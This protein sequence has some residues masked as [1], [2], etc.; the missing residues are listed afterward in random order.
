MNLATLGPALAFA[1]ISIC[2]PGPNN[3]ASAAM[4][5]LYG[6]RKTLPFLVGIC[7]SF[8]LMCLVSAWVARTLLAR[9]PALEALLTY[10]GAAYVIY[11]AVNILKTSYQFDA[12]P[13]ATTQPAGLWAGFTLQL[14]NPKFLVFAL[15]LFSTFFA[16][17]ARQ[18]RSLVLIA[19]GLTLISA[20]SVSS[21]T[22]F[23]SWVRQHMHRPALRH[24]VNLLLALLLAYSA[25]E[26]VR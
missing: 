12:R 22:L 8:F 10:A 26:M 25:L 17:E 11:L 20:F 13:S 3:I 4:G 2:T 18:A 16:A 19:L 7:L 24:T 6:F 23:G 1:L 21:W 5:T 15:T 9:F 14:L